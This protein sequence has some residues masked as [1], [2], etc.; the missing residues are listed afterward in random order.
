MALMEA[1]HKLVLATPNGTK[2]HMDEASDSAM[3]FGGDKAAYLRARAFWEKD[4][5]M[6]QVR[7]LRSVIKDGLD[8]Y[9]AVFVP[10]GQAPVVDLMQDP[11]AG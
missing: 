5:V 3:H 8:S 11:D 6:N 1:G 4:P 9:D 2:P 10:G 7:T